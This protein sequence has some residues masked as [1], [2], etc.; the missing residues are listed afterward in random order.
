MRDSITSYRSNWN[1]GLSPVLQVGTKAQEE[2]RP[3]PM[4]PLPALVTEWLGRRVVAATTQ[5]RFL[6]SQGSLGK[7]RAAAM[8]PS[9]LAVKVQA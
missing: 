4:I 2:G 1:F 7:S 6:A 9:P 5:V 8:R 3:P